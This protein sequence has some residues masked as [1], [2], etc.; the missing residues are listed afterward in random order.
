VTLA[1]GGHYWVSVQVVKPSGSPQPQWLWEERTTA[2]NL[3]AVWQNPGNAFQQTTCTSWAPLGSCYFDLAGSD[4]LFGLMGTSSMVNSATP[5]LN[6]ISPVA[7]YNTMIPLSLSGAN[8]APGAVI[9]W[10]VTSTAPVTIT[11]SFGNSNSLTADIPQAQVLPA[12]T[13]ASVVVVNPSPCSSLCV[14]NPLTFTIDTLQ[15]IYVPFIRR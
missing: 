6:Q 11:T 14:S 2:A 5:V 1:A 8:F 13:K 12:G 4:L 9:S 15:S 3:P 10:T 7:A